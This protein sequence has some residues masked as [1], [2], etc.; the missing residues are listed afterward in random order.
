M[1]L[2]NYTKFSSY[3]LI[4]GGNSVIQKENFLKQ[5]IFS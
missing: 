2:V 1:K 3:D 5:G 4:Y